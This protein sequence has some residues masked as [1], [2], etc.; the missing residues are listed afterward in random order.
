MVIAL[1]QKTLIAPCG[2]P[3]GRKH[4][5]MSYSSELY[6]YS[7]LTTLMPQC[8]GVMVMLTSAPSVANP[9]PAVGPTGD[10]Q[11]GMC[12]LLAPL[13][14]PSPYS[15]STVLINSPCPYNNLTPIIP[16]PYHCSPLPTAP[17]LASKQ[18]QIWWEGGSGSI[19]E[20]C[21]PRCGKDEYPPASC[22]ML[23][24]GLLAQPQATRWK[25][26]EGAVMAWGLEARGLR[27]SEGKV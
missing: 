4:R 25:E 9:A 13:I 17:P 15:R 16:L 27:Q 7:Y 8:L 14:I 23:Q 11:R 21:C 24:D 12:T 19:P 10:T 22:A 6:L 20:E 3:L 18:H 26:W 5:S 2:P 1:V